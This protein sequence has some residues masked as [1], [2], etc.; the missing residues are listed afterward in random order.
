MASASPAAP[1]AEI[2]SML[3]DGAARSPSRD[4]LE[5]L[6]YWLAEPQ[7]EKGAG[8][9]AELE[10]RGIETAWARRMGLMLLE[11]M[12]FARSD[13]KPHELL[14]VEPGTRH[15]ALRERYHLLMR[16]YHPDR[17]GGDA[18][19]LHD[20]AER[21]NGAYTTITREAGR[22]AP[23][24][25]P[26]RVPQ[27]PVT[28]PRPRLRRRRA[29]RHRTSRSLAQRVAGAGDPRRRLIAAIAAACA[30]LMIHACVTHQ[31]WRSLDAASEREPSLRSA[32]ARR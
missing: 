3:V 31:S 11:E 27:I 9:A 16:V 19:W 30:A 32:E 18:Q 23:P 5:V 10:R 24:R 17:G 4:R 12:L 15:D 13:A 28:Y 8:I 6:L 14:G 7:H 20:R 25:A 29:R 26:A 2:V 22:D 1:S 21:V